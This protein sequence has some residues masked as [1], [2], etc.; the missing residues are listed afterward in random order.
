MW[1]IKKYI[2][3]TGKR[4][5]TVQEKVIFISSSG[6]N[7]NQPVIIRTVKNTN[8]ESNKDT[9]SPFPFLSFSP[10]QVYCLEMSV[11]EMNLRRSETQKIL[12]MNFTWILR[13]ERLNQL[14]SGSLLIMQIMSLHEDKSGAVSIAAAREVKWVFVKY[15]TRDYEYIGPISHTSNGLRNCLW[16]KQLYMLKAEDQM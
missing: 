12:L 5:W 9:N 15:L 4:P 2:I 8:E 13:G 11:C 7:V 16:Q 1:S 10:S 14:L 6:E 3:F